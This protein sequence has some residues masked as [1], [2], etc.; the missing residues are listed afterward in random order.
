MYSLL[1]LS[2]AS[3]TDQ[4]GF[5]FTPPILLLG[6]VL[7]AIDLLIQKTQ[8]Q[9]YRFYLP[10]M[11]A[12][13]LIESWILWGNYDEWRIINEEDLNGHFN[14]WNF[15]ILLWMGIF[16]ALSICFRPIFMRVRGR[17]FN[18][19]LVFLIVFWILVTIAL[20][21]FLLKVNKA[22]QSEAKQYIS[23]MNKG[24]QAYYAGNSALTNSFDALELGFKTE[25]NNYKYSICA[26]KTAS[27]HYAVAKESMLKNYVGGV[28]IVPVY[29]NSAKDEMMTETIL[30]EAE[31]NRLIKFKPADE[32]AEPTYQNGEVICGKGTTE[33]TR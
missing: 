5:A 1:I 29:S 8:P 33:L 17:N 25:T 3:A 22:K 10:I 20:P 24:Q 13:A 9:K 30:C 12:S 26:T 7:S 14:S 31:D 4:P 15:D 23:S 28:F 19:C 16:L 32:P 2:L 18:D 27:I 21:S 6:V 11:G